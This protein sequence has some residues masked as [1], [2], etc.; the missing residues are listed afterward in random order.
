V[1]PTQ[2]SI[3]EDLIQ[4]AKL[5]FTDEPRKLY[6]GRLPKGVS[7]DFMEKL[8]NCCGE[9]K[10]WK[11]SRDASNEPKPFGYAEYDNLEAVFAVMK[12]LNNAAITADNTTSRMLVRADEK[13]TTF[14][15]GW[16]EIKKQEW[17]GK[18]DKLGVKIDREDLE[19]KEA[20]GEIQPYE[21]ELIPTYDSMN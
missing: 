6:I 10:S 14:L 12:L 4:P 21:R 19:Q 9:L 3:A 5:S 15:N 11:R 17:I 20:L 16:V 7:D 1:V 18:I 13:T 2:R 8:L